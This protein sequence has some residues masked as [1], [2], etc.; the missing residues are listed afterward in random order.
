VLIDDNTITGLIGATNAK[1]ILYN[2][3]T[4]GTVSNNVISGFTCGVTVLG[5]ADV[6]IGAGNDLSANTTETCTS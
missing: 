3:D 1:G 2:P 5:D 6:T 4:K